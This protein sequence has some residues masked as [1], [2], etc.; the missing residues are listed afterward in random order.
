MYQLTGVNIIIDALLHSPYDHIN[1]T[2][3]FKYII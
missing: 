3:R 2:N 1:K